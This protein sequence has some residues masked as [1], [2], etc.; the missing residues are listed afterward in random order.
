[1]SDATPILH[2]L[3]PQK[4]MSP[5]DVNMAADA[6]Y[7]VIIPYINVELA[8]VTGLIQDAIFSRP[9]NYGVRT[10]FFMGGKDAILALD[11]LEAA[12]KA[13]VPPFECSC[14]ADPA[15]SFTTAAAMVACVEKVLKEKFGKTWKGTKVAVFGATGVVGFASSIISA[16]EGAE[17]KLVAH[18]GIDRVI[19]NAKI[20]KERFGVDLEPVPGETEEQKS[21]IIANAEVIFAAAAAGVRV[22]S[23]ENMH[24]AKNLLVMADVNAVPPPGVEGMELFMN[25]EKLL[26]TETLGVGPL[27]IGDIKYKCES[28]LFK[29]MIDSDVPL[30]LDFRHAYELS[31]KLVGLA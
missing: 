30:S 2:M 10:G 24:K 25:G 21:E 29:Q 28:G 5:F 1:M 7:K 31:K 19:K 3:A 14:F 13:M 12:K 20:S 23:K 8:E 22:V 11:M 16:L 15:G 4:H 9:P 26:D 18:R 17:V 6:G 27:A